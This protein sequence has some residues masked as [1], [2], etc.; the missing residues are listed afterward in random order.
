VDEES[1][2]RG[3]PFFVDYKNR[4]W[5]GSV[6]KVI[7]SLLERGRV[8]ETTIFSAEADDDDALWLFT[9]LLI[10]SADYEEQ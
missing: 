6:A 5:H 3:K 7:E 10:L 9:R 2:H 1:E 8:G 4:V